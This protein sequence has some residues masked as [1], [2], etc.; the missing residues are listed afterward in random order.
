MHEEAI[1]SAITSAKLSY[2]LL[3]HTMQISE[4]SIERVNKYR[5]MHKRNQSYV[6]E[7]DTVGMSILH[8]CAFKI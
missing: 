4:Q 2:I 3:Q 8:L 7:N 1:E 6:E 5:S